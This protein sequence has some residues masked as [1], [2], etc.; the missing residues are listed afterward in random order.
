MLL[1]VIVFIL[2]VTVFSPPSFPRSHSKLVLGEK[3]CKL[4]WCYWAS[5][6]RVLRTILLWVSFSPSW[7]K[8]RQWRM[9]SSAVGHILQIWFPVLSW[10]YGV[11]SLVLY[12]SSM[13][14]S[15]DGKTLENVW[16]VKKSYS[17]YECIINSVCIFVYLPWQVSFLWALVSPFLRI[18]FALSPGDNEI[19]VISREQK[20]HDVLFLCKTKNDIS[21]EGGRLSFLKLEKKSIFGMDMEQTA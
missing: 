10:P 6:W 5:S 4:W 12:I 2:L 19:M 17:S 9:G 1:F 8:A 7:N 3:A 11:E 15:C 13:G 21:I 16:F 20:D 18:I 14:A